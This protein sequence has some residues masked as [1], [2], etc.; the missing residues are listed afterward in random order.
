M[1]MNAFLLLHPESEAIHH[2]N[3]G[4][5]VYINYCN[6]VDYMHYTNYSYCHNC[7]EEDNV[8]GKQKCI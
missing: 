7:H 4:G 1:Y 2:F 8:L 6:Y 3:V 5:G